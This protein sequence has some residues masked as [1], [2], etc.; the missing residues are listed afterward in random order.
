MAFR[1]G[2]DFNPHSIFLVEIGMTSHFRLH[3][4]VFFAAFPDVTDAGMVAFPTHYDTRE[5]TPQLA[6]SS[7]TSRALFQSWWERYNTIFH[8][9][10]AA[11]S[12]NLI[13]HYRGEVREVTLIEVPYDLKTHWAWLT[14]N[15]EESIFLLDRFLVF[16]STKDA[17]M[18][19]LQFRG[20]N[21]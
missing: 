14:C 13:P 6:F 10:R 8:N 4:D 11:T 9:G 16:T 19:E 2:K 17:V 3:L 18:Y 12:S 20:K 15:A 7:E 21:D 5:A 1:V